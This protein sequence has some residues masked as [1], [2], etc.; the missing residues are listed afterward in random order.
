MATTV[1]LHTML[2]DLDDALRALFE[3][4]LA[5]R[6]LRDT[7]VSFDAPAEAWAERRKGP[8]LDLYLYDVTESH[9]ER[10]VEW[11]TDT[12]DGRIMERPPPVL[13]EASYVITGWADSPEDE[14]RLLSAALAVAY[15]HPQLPDDVRSGVLADEWSLQRP[16]VTRVARPSGDA[17]G[18]GFW[19]A[20][21]ARPKP[22][23]DFG[24]A[25][26]CRPERGFDQAPPVETQTVRV[27]VQGRRAGGVQELHRISGTVRV[28]GTPAQGAWVVLPESGGFCVADAD[29]RFTIAPVASGR[30]TVQ[31]RGPSGA[32]AEATVDVPGGGSVELKLK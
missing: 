17:V 23:V 9:E 32:E 19:A 2:G 4:E 21:G 13:V 27:S 20:M 22:S 24:V 12:V 5:E 6:G 25:V 14:H 18:A 3:R 29:G 30:H 26:W 10:R 28:G 11:E 16:L 7:G 1:G 15:A 31:A 8:V